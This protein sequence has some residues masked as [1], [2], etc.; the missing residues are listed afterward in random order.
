MIKFLNRVLLEI[1]KLERLRQRLTKNLYKRAVRAGAKLV[2]ADLRS[3]VPVVSNALKKSI[4]SKVDSPKGETNAY[5]VIGPRSRYTM[6]VRGQV[7]KPSRYFHFQES[8]RF[9]RP[10]LYPT[11]S[12][13][14]R[15][16]LE[17]MNNVLKEGINEH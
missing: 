5:A 16:Y 17:A 7:K 14:Q 1:Q 6:T 11:F 9:A 13:G 2:V 12:A 3:R 4:S 10:V 8:G 15:K